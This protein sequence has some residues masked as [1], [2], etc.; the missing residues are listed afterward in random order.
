MF[1]FNRSHDMNSIQWKGKSGI[2]CREQALSNTIREKTIL[3]KICEDERNSAYTRMSDYQSPSGGIPFY[4]IYCFP[5]I[6]ASVFGKGKYIYICVCAC[7]CI[8]SSLY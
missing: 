5:Q 7:V 6:P 3:S 8:I 1:V 4:K 2:Y